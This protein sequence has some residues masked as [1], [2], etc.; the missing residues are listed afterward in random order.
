MKFVYVMLAGV[1]SLALG[2]S[3][4]PSS[5]IAQEETIDHDN[6]VSRPLPDYVINQ[7]PETFSNAK[8]VAFLGESGIG[9]YW[10][11]ELGTDTCVAFYEKIDEGFMS[12]SCEETSKVD[13]KG[14]SSTYMSVDGNDVYTQ[15]AWFTGDTESEEKADEAVVK[16]HH[17]KIEDASNEAKFDTGKY[18]DDLPEDKVLVDPVSEGKQVVEIIRGEEQE[19]S[20][21]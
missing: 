16:L 7:E 1:A 5:S 18:L 20:V 11:F 10:Q 6:A 8:N 2:G 17:E 3:L 9:E 15:D 12:L 13:E 14:I 4:F 19:L 21:D